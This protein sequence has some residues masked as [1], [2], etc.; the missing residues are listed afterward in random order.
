MVE[1]QCPFLSKSSPSF[2]LGTLLAD[3]PLQSVLRLSRA[4]YP[5][6]CCGNSKESGLQYVL[7]SPQPGPLTVPSAAPPPSSVAILPNLALLRWYF[8]THGVP[9]N[10]LL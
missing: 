7:T 8:I 5:A 10:G 9:N 6:Q 1:Y 2:H 3:L 4:R